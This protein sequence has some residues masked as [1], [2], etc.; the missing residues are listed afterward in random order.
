MIATVR[1]FA[2][3][4]VQEGMLVS[5]VQSAVMHERAREILVLTGAQMELMEFVGGV[6]CGSEERVEETHQ[7]WG[8]QD[9]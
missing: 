7:F 4:G 9:G 6:R 3:E 1:F 8:G 2:E 5:D